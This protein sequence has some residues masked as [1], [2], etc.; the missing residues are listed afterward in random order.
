MEDIIKNH[1]QNVND[2][3]FFAAVMT[4]DLP[5]A[6]SL[7]DRIMKDKDFK[8]EDYIRWL[9]NLPVDLL[10]TMLPNSEDGDGEIKPLELNSEEQR[11]ILISR[12]LLKFIDAAMMIK[13]D[14][15]MTKLINLVLE[16]GAHPLRRDYRHFPMLM[17]LL[18]EANEKTYGVEGIVAQK[19][20][21]EAERVEEI[22]NETLLQLLRP[23]MRKGA[24][25]V[26]VQN[27]M[28]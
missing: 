22:F 3:L 14:E 16:R 12:V 9:W 13:D 11:A 18:A 2:E 26:Q 21:V 7:V 19:E 4:D 23:E 20:M 25:I 10:E 1:S 17:T 6:T 15:K 24:T 5:L 27:K 28:H 8:F